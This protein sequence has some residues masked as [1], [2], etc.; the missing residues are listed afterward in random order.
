MK[1]SE[2]KQWFKDNEVNPKTISFYTT[3][4]GESPDSQYSTC[5]ITG[6][7]CSVADCIALTLDNEVID[8]QISENLIGGIIGKL[9]GAF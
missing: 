7:T 6:E 1:N 3:K 8:L 4:D 9:A 5:D 2:V